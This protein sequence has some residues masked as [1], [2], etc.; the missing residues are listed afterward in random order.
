MTITVHPKNKKELRK[1]KAI[2]KAID[3]DFW[4]VKEPYNEEFVSKIQKS[5]EEIKNG[6]TRKIALEDLW[7]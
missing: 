1:I 4:E 5:R 7:K 2:L 6:K 3:A